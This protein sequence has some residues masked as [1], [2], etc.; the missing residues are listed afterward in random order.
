MV[1]NPPAMWET[2]AWSLGREDPLEEG[3][4]INSSIVAWR[5]PQTEEPGGLQ[6]MGSQSQDTAEWLNTWL[7]NLAVFPVLYGISL[8]LYFIHNSLYFLTPIPVLSLSPLVTI[9]VFSVSVSL[10]PFCY[11]HYFYF[12][13]SIY[14]WCDIYSICLSLTYFT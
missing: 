9:S 7:Y 2:Q 3:M 1:K 8:L 6:S 10:F 11:I 4:A 5:I 12:V 14:K 13:D